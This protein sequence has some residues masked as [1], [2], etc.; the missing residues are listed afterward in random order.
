M[1]CVCVAAIVVPHLHFCEVLQQSH[2][3]LHLTHLQSQPLQLCKLG[4][5]KDSKLKGLS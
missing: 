5:L 4:G 1:L 3:R 2:H